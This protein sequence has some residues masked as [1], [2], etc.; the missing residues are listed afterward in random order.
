MIYDL[1]NWRT[2]TY[3]MPFIGITSCFYLLIS[4]KVC[5]KRIAVST[6]VCLF[7]MVWLLLTWADWGSVVFVASYQIM[8]VRIILLLI[9]LLLAYEIRSQRQFISQLKHKNVYLERKNDS[10]TTNLH[11]LQ[12]QIDKLKE[13]NQHG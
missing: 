10:L 11:I 6:S 5:T 2:I 9:G 7:L 8:W 3:I 1:I 12:N 4:R 13:G